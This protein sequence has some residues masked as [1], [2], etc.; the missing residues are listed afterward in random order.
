MFG[1]LAA[2][3]LLAGFVDSIAG[4]G[5]LITV[6]AFTLLL[7][8]GPD[9]IGTNKIVGT[10]ATSVAMFIYMRGGHV[11]L[12]GHWLFFLCVGASSALGA[13]MSAWV[14]P[15]IYKWLVV[16]I[17]PILLFVIIK[18]DLWIKEAAGGDHSHVNYKALWMAGCA[19]GFYDGIAGPGGGTL[20]FLALFVLARFP[21]LGAMA[22]A[23]VANLA[24]AS[25]SL[26]TYAYHGHVLWS[27]G[28]AMAIGI[29]MGSAVGASVASKN[30]AAWARIALGVVSSLLALRL[31]F[32]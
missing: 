11:R 19:C 23:K 25:V 9:A 17:V 6:P 20:M 18:K 4:G 21:L 8:P 31:I 26:V 27:Q 7:G 30:A 12:K 14:P 22:T 24:S 2:V 5:G 16:A 32:T 10:V 28:V 13:Y 15:P 3:G 1:L 29:A